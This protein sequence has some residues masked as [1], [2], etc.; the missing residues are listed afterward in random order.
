MRLIVFL[1]FLLV[2]LGSCEVGSGSYGQ[3]ETAAELES[4]NPASESPD[5]VGAWTSLFGPELQKADY[6]P[7]IWSLDSAGDLTATEDIHI[8][9]Q[10]DYDD[11]DLELEFKTA[12]G[13]N[14]GVILHCSN[15]D[16]WI[17]NSVEVQI[18]DNYNEK[19]ASADPNWKC[20]AIF[21]HQP[22]MV[23]DAVHPPGE[24]N[25]YYI[26][27]R[28]PI[29]TVDLNGQ[30]VNELDMRRYDSASVNPD[31]SEVPAWLS[32]PLAELPT[33]GKIG[34]QGKH[35]G[36]PVWFR[37]LRVRRVY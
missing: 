19:W 18:A 2:S 33:Q 23:E 8:W 20:G 14:S 37:N 36:A 12:D 13:T 30:R 16:D 10:K 26:T 4:D 3:Q 21:G 24:W 35:A 17:P 7:N 1:T 31:G 11:F 5:S 6:D 32:K 29:V 22:A 27:A 34:L 15:V 28:G 25:R 9:T